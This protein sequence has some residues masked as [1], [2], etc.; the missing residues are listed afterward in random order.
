[1]STTNLFDLLGLPGGGFL[2]AEPQ[3]QLPAIAAATT[4]IRI[5]ANNGFDSQLLD[6]FPEGVVPAD[7]ATDALEEPTAL[8]LAAAAD[9]GRGLASL[10]ED[11]RLEIATGTKPLAENKARQGGGEGRKRKRSSTVFV[12]LHDDATDTVKEHEFAPVELLKKDEVAFKKFKKDMSA[13]AVVDAGALEAQNRDDEA[14][15]LRKR[16]LEWFAVYRNQR[17]RL[18]NSF[19]AKTHRCKAAA[20][21]KGGKRLEEQYRHQ[22]AELERSHAIIK[23]LEREMGKAVASIAVLRR[24]VTQQAAELAALQPGVAK[25]DKAGDEYFPDD[26]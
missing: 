18:L 4:P 22:E 12:R 10:F 2:D 17:R 3:T 8:P 21:R 19:Y 23:R 5:P 14:A 9:Q 11:A 15:A 6:M 20:K 13:A 26:V 16:R 7:S 1:M 24:R 25:D